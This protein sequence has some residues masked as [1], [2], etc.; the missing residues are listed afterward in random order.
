MSS[1][2]QECIKDYC[3]LH[4]VL[5]TIT[6]LTP[7]TAKENVILSQTVDTLMLPNTLYKFSL[8]NFEIRFLME[9]SRP[10]SQPT[11]DGPPAH[12]LYPAHILVCNLC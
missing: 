7:V 12:F 10:T 11:S 1:V 2:Q 3:R 5:G 6:V 8:L 9:W 4:T